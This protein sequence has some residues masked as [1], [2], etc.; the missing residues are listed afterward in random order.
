[1]LANKLKEKAKVIHCINLTGLGGV[2]QSF[3]PFYNHAC[4][5]S[6]FN[7]K[8][9]G[10]GAIDK[11]YSNVSCYVNLS[12]SL[13]KNLQYLYYLIDRRSVIHFYNN[14]GG[15]NISRLLRFLP[16]SNIVF[17]ERGTVWNAVDSDRK[18]Y[19]SNAANSQVIIANSNATKLMLIRKMEIPPDKIQVIYNGFFNKMCIKKAESGPKKIVGYVG[20]LDTPKGVNV[21]IKAAKVLENDKDV[22]FKIAGRGHLES[23]LREESSGMKNIEF[24]GRVTNPIEFMKTIDL[25]VVPSIR[26]PFG[27]VIVEAGYTR[28]PVIATMVDGIPEIIDNGVSG[29]LLPPTEDVSLSDVPLMPV[30]VVDPENKELVKPK[31]LNAELLAHSINELLHDEARQQRYADNL[32]KHVTSHF[33]LDNYF[34][35]VEAVYSDILSG[36]FR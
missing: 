16:C 24:V 11:E 20:R 23:F 30:C 3:V 1:M 33:T 10:K 36:V 21:L 17:S 2:Q 13:Y 15:P 7:Y 26:E 4:R 19:K 28:L 12:D 6:L 32:Y 8:V 31:E 18:Y 34:Q 29:L 27:N 9:F 14:L 25:L 35:S 22:V 5:N